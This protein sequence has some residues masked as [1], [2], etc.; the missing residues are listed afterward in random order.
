MFHGFMKEKSDLF[1]F[2]HHEQK[3]LYSEERICCMFWACHVFFPQ[4]RSPMISKNKSSIREEPRTFI[5]EPTSDTSDMGWTQLGVQ[6]CATPKPK[7]SY[8]DQSST[9]GYEEDF[10]TSSIEGGMA[11]MQYRDTWWIWQIMAWS[12]RGHSKMGMRKLSKHQ[13]YPFVFISMMSTKT[14]LMT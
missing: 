4:M 10:E 12:G 1:G 2:F 7:I 3:G 9:F 5:L 13:I 11:L 14:A 8:S 6:E